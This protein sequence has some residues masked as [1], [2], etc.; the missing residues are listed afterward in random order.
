MKKFLSFIINHPLYLIVP[1]IVLFCLDVEPIGAL[2]MVA[3][4]VIFLV[5][6]FGNKGNKGGGSV[7]STE[8]AYLMGGDL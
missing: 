4:G 5:R 6:H 1:G 2:L 7:S 3:G 8:G